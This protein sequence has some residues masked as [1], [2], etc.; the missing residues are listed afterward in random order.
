MTTDDASG[1]KFYHRKSM[2]AEA[3]WERPSE[4]LAE[5]PTESAADAAT[6]PPNG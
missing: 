2:S 6:K 4:P 3:Q 1:R 5:L